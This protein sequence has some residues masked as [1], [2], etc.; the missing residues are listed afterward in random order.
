M[1]RNR[2]HVLERSVCRQDRLE[3]A[4]DEAQSEGEDEP[5]DPHPSVAAAQEYRQL[6]QLLR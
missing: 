3:D 1:L 2:G 6:S 5:G 4:D